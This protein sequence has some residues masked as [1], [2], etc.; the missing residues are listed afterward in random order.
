MESAKMFG[1]DFR[2]VKATFLVKMFGLDFRLVKAIFLVK[3]SQIRFM[4]YNSLYSAVQEDIC[5][6]QVV[7]TLYL[8]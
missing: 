7:T 3:M 8:C 5:Y 6:S 2:L 4:V 1:L